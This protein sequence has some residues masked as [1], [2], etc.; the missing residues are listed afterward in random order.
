MSAPSFTI[1]AVALG[2]LLM[3]SA[4]AGQWPHDETGAS[5]SGVPASFDCAMRKL[6]YSHGKQL[7]PRLGGFD[8]LF[9]ALGL[10]VDCQDATEPPVRT[11]EPLVPA[12]HRAVPDS[13]VYADAAKGT[14]GAACGASAASPCQTIQAAADRAGAGGT[15]VLGDGGVFYLSTAVVLT[16]AHSGLTIQAAPGASP[17]VSGGVELDAPA[18]RR[19]GNNSADTFTT[20]DNVNVV[21]PGANNRTIFDA[22]VL[23]DA[24]TCQ[25]ACKAVGAGCT[26]YTW[27][28]QTVE[29]A[30]RGHCLWRNDGVYTKTAQAGHFS[31]QHHVAENVWVADISGSGVKTVPGLQVDGVR[32]TRARYPNLPGGIEASCGYGCMVD[33]HQGEW[34]PPDFNK[35]GNVT[36]YTDNQTATWRNN[37]PS[38][39]FQVKETLRACTTQRGRG[40]PTD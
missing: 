8:P 34:T 37:T 11:S 17:V 32:A 23:S 1:R 28:D 21:E 2:S 4:T 7:L 16:S 40:S 39:W 6:A 35:Y 38:N 18:W 20:D 25:Q 27:H 10:N 26:G 14:D 5:L 15:V 30:Y 29:A 3:S 13:A 33:S 12:A 9:D 19:Y 36:F 31:G 22:G 24:A